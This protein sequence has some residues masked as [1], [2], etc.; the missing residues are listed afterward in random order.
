MFQLKYKMGLIPSAQKIDQAWEELV[1][2]REELQTIENSAELKRYNE[3]CQLT[4]SYEFQVQKKE[5]QNLRFQESQECQMLKELLKLEKDRAIQDYYK[6]LNSNQLQRFETVNSSAELK[7]YL[8]LKKNLESMAKGSP[9]YKEYTQLSRNQEIVFHQKFSQ[10]IPYKNFTQV[11]GSYNLERL[12]ELRKQTA[13]PEFKAR[14][15]YLKNKNRYR[16]TELFAQEKEL[17]A[18]EDS[19]W[20]KKYRQLQKSSKLD[21]FK[22]WSLVFEEDFNK[23]KLDKSLW[24]TENYRGNKLNGKSFSQ[25]DEA[26]AY[27]GEKNIVLNGNTLSI[28]TKQEKV[29]GQSWNAAVGLLPKE[30]DYSSG[31]INS[32]ESFRFKEGVVEAKVKFKA[33]DSL[34]NAFSLTGSVPMPQIDIFRSGKD[35]VGVG[36]TEK[37]GNGINRKYKQICG[38][39]FNQYHVFRLEKFDH[40]LVWKINGEQVHTEYYTGAETELFLNFV[41]SLHEPVNKELFPHHFEIDWVRCFAKNN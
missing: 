26:Q 34:T 30:F 16:T 5:I 41:S 20:M 12:E 29:K 22:Q 28:L 21:F 39:N 33:A 7:Q 15:A 17:K 25:A 40:T 1:K 9:E 3:L 27:N 23:G 11:K 38:L 31:I 36:Y 10:S 24:Q 6:I 14:V 2:L 8:R 32:A 35:C 19:T 37:N 18:L 13:E 4:A